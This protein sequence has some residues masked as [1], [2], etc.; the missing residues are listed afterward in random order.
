MQVGKLTSCS[1]HLSKHCVLAKQPLDGILAELAL[2]ILEGCVNAVAVQLVA[3]VS[4]HHC[5]QHTTAVSVHDKFMTAGHTRGEVAT[6]GSSASAALRWNTGCSSNV[7]GQ[8]ITQRQAYHT[9]FKMQKS[10]L[11][12]R[13]EGLAV[14]V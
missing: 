4:Q 12:G 11:I 3:A 14:P 1:S 2:Q 10:Y 5:L 8:T 6:L 13:A 9:G 7:Q